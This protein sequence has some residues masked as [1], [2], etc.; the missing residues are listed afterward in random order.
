MADNDEFDDIADEDL[1]LAFNQTSTATAQAL[2]SGNDSLGSRTRQNPWSSFGN[3][4]RP[5]GQ[6]PGIFS[7]N[8]SGG[9][10]QTVRLN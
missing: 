7:R 4:S 9:T 10:S 5:L 1:V 2:A 8:S 3:S 6:T